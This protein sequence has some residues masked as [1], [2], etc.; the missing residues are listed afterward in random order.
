MLSSQNGTQIRMMQ[1][2]FLKELPQSGYELYNVHAQQSAFG[3]PSNYGKGKWSQY[4]GKQGRSG[5]GYRRSF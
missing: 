2:R 3:N 1:S 5:G 4:G